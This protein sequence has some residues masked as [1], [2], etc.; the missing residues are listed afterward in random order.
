MNNMSGFFY[1]IIPYA[2]ADGSNPSEPIQLHGPGGVT[3]VQDL[4]GKIV[5]FG[6]TILVPVL[7]IMV[8]WGAY[9]MLTARDDVGQF[10]KGKT[11]ITYAAIGAAIILIGDGILLVIKNFLGA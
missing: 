9:L 1:K 8:L 4:L 3:T 10:K 7:T 11:T 6:Y 5:Q 2:Y